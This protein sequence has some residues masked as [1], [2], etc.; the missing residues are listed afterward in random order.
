MKDVKCKKADL[1]DKLRANRDVHVREY[2][3]ACAGYR[4]QALAKVDEIMDQLKRQISALKE[5]EAV[6]LANIFFSLPAPE[7]HAADYD[8]VLTMLS[9]SVDDEITLDQKSFSQYVMDNWDWKESWEGTKMSYS[10]RH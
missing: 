3:E 2:K 9:M 5:G 10:A 1:I 7:S 8:R 6:P 4:D